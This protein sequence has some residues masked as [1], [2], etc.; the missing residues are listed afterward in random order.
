[1]TSQTEHGISIGIKRINETFFIKMKLVGKL[2]HE[3]YKTIVPMIENSLKNVE[4]PDVSLLVDA[5]QFEGWSLEAA[6]DDLKIGLKHNEDF[7]KI[8]F[9]GNKSWQEYGIKISN[10]FMFGTMEYF[11]KMD[12][13]KNWLE[14]KEVTK[15]L[16]T[17]QKELI[18]REEDI[19]NQLESLFQLNMKITDWDVP[20]P[21]NQKAAELIIEILEKKLSKIKNDVIN[22]KYEYY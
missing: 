6:F 5:T 14:T 21:D 13:A 20:E 3:D 4:H 18:S 16:T 12:E 11:E 15:N 19:E 1:M 2:T 7:K 9:V 8:A 17:T 22:G 10:W